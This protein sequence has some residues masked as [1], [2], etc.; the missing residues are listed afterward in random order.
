MILSDTVQVRW[1]SNLKKWYL[2]KGYAYTKMYDYFECKVEDLMPTST[3]K[4]KVKCDYCGKIHEKEYRD[5]IKQREVIERDCCSSRLCGKIKTREICIKLHGVDDYSK[6]DYV[7]EKQSKIRRTDFDIVINAFKDKNLILLSDESDY[8]NDRSRLR[9]I[10]NNHK[11]HG[12]QETSFANIKN[13][14]GCCV[15]KRGEL[16]SEVRRFNGEFIIE[17]FKN[18]GFMPLFEPEDYINNETKLPCICLQHEEKGVQYIPYVTLNSRKGCYYCSKESTKNKLKLKNEKVF[19]YFE[20][21][22]LIISDSETYTNKETKIKCTCKIHTDNHIHISY[23][24]LKKISQPCNLCREELNTTNLSKRLRGCLNSWKNESK[25]YCNNVCVLTN[26]KS[27]QI[28]HVYSFKD[29]VL[30]SLSNLGIEIKD[31]YS[32]KEILL[33]KE[34]TKRL[35]DIYPLGICIHPELHTLLHS[36][37]GKNTNEE[38]LN[39]FMNNYFNYIYDDKLS[40]EVKYSNIA[41]Y[42]EKSA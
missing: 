29:I 41:P 32:S 39:K 17:E 2:E 42:V 21:R 13:L 28:H 31:D 20:S 19:N 22:N 5:Y 11:E 3:I 40:N 30:E 10:C 12:I 26:S 14:K 24:Q 9:F 7:R 1:I 33:L 37:F 6:L 23:G 25:K 4:I 38:D 15:Y 18:N 27:Y 8:K 36:E 34:E 35:H 16:V